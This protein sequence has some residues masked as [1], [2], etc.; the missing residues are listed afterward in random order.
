MSKVIVTE[1]DI[2]KLFKDLLDD[3][4]VKLRSGEATGK[5]KELV[6]KLVDQY[7]ICLSYTSP[8]PR[9]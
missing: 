4:S 6:V 5:D 9:D 3:L 1:N 7:Q 2:R 8:S